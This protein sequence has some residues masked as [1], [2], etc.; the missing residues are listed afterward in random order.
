MHLFSVL[1]D[2]FI[3]IRVENDHSVAFL[4]SVQYVGYLGSRIE[5]FIDDQSK[6][7]DTEEV[8]LR[9]QDQQNVPSSPLSSS[10]NAAA[11][12]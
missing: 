8:Y 7:G 11:M 9:R 3:Q 6:N 10:N 1:S 2:S 4:E 5:T 12:N